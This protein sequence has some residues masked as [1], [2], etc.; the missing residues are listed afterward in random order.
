MVATILPPKALAQ[1]ASVTDGAIRVGPLLGIP[2]LLSELGLDPGAVILEAGVDPSLF[3]DPENFIGFAAMGRLLAHC[4]TRTGCPHFG[5]LAGQRMG[6][7]CVGARGHAVGAFSRRGQ[8]PEQCGPAL[9][10]A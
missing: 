7:D 2:P 1:V 6:L 4:A 8:C 5:L 9:A 10:P 3:D